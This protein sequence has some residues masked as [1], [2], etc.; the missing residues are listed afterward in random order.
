VLLYFSQNYCC[1]PWGLIKTLFSL[2]QLSREQLLEL[3]DSRIPA[4]LASRVEVDALPPSFVARRSLELLSEG[5]PEFWCNTFLIVQNSTGKIIGGCGF[6]NEPKD[7]RVEIGYGVSPNSRGQGAATEAV[8]LLLNLALSGGARQV[9][10]EVTPE[11]LASTRVVQKLGFI[12]TGTHVD[13]DNDIV[14][15]WVW[16]NDL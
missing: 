16:K 5:K 12:N 10:A 2:L 6:K 1:K 3:A 14:V 7:G 13:E 11:N 15:Q 8:K 9:L 4:S